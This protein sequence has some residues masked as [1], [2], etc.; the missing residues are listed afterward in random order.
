MTDS[1]Y[2]LLEQ[3]A[4]QQGPEAAIEL[5]ID[6]F[7]REKRFHELF[8]AL[9]IRS[10]MR[11]GLP[12]ILTR[13]LDDLEE[14]LRTQVEEAYLEACRE[15]GRGLLEQGRVREAWT[16][17][18]PPGE[19]EPVAEALERLEATEENLD[20][21]IEVAVH[22]GVSPRRGFQLVLEHYGICNAITLYDAQMHFRPREQQQ[23]VAALLLRHLHPELLENV[24]ADVARREGQ[25]PEASTLEELVSGRPWLFENDAYHIDTSHLHSVVRFARVLERPE[26]LKLAADLCSYGKHLGPQ[27]QFQNEEPFAGGYADYERFFRAQLGQGTEEHLE[28]FAQKARSLSVEEHG[29]APA[30]VYVELLSRLGRV[31]EALE[32]AAE[33][34]PAKAATTGFAPSLLELASRSG[35]Y[36]RLKEISRRRGDVLG[37]VAGLLEDRLRQAAAES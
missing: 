13:S 17:L 6:H 20:E 19:V 12:V 3:Q 34:I 35:R 31:E 9:L 11:F 7:R 37:F 15:V 26:E 10:R 30:E 29:T 22:E 21:L 18:R 36:D 5:L 2:D 27:F 1:L 23:E 25:A 28:F 16:Y 4:R 33:L 14:P 8:D 24:K 32:A